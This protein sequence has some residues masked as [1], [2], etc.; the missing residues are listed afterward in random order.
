VGLTVGILGVLEVCRDGAAVPVAG[1]RAQLLLHLLAAAEGRTVSASAL[2]EEIWGGE[3]A[4]D[5]ANA[6][7]SLVSR[8]R[9]MLGDAGAV[10]Q[11][12][13]GYRLVADLDSHRFAELGDDDP[14]AA[15]RLW[16]GLPHL[17]LD[18]RLLDQDRQRLQRLHDSARLRLA[19]RRLEAGEA[20]A[21]L[22][23]LAGLVAERPLD[24]RARELHIRALHA[25]GRQAEALAAYEE[26]RVL[27]RDE[28]GVDPSPTLQRL[29]RD[30]LR[31]DPSLV[32]EPARLP[33]PVSTFIGREEDLARIRRLLGDN[34]LVTLVGPGGAGKTRLALEAARDAGDARL[35]ELAPLRSGGDIPG[36]VADALG[37]REVN[38]SDRQ[39]VPTDAL[40]RACEHL[41]GRSAL[42]VLDNCEHLVEDAARVAHE[43]LSG[44]P[45]L[46][47]LATSREP[48]GVTG[49][50][51]LSV[52]ALPHADGLRLF[53]ERALAARHDLALDEEVAGR[54]VDR[55]D[56]MPLAIEL[57]A[58]R[59]RTLSP[60]EIDRRL[61]DRFR[62]LTV[63]SRTAAPR[64]QTLRAVIDWSWA[65]LDEDERRV[66]RRL[67]V[68]AGDATLD[69]A[70]AVCGEGT[71]P[72]LSSLVD[73]SLVVLRDA[74][75]IAYR[76][77][78]TVRA[79]ARDRLR[80]AGDESEARNLHAA[81]L[82]ALVERCDGRLRG[83]GQIDAMRELDAAMPDVQTAVDW[84]V[85]SGAGDLSHRLV[86]GLTYYFMVR[87]GRGTEGLIDRVSAMPPPDD[88][89]LRATLLDFAVV[90]AG[91][92]RGMEWSAEHNAEA[93]RLY[94]RTDRP[95]LPY[96]GVMAP[97][98]AGA[99]NDLEAAVHAA[100]E[101]AADPRIGPWDRAMTH[102]VIGYLTSSSPAPEESEEAFIRA[103]AEFQA[104][105][106]RLGTAGALSGL[107]R[108]A[109]RRDHPDEAI[110]LLEEA[111][112]HAQ[113]LGAHEDEVEMRLRHGS[114]VA[115]YR[116]R[117]RGLREL[118]EAAREAEALGSRELRGH[119]TLLRAEVARLDGDPGP[120]RLLYERAI[121][122]VAGTNYIPPL[123]L[124]ARLRLAQMA[125]AAR[126]LDEARRRLTEAIDQLRGSARLEIWRPHL[127]VAIWFAAAGVALA[128]GEAP[129]AARLL[130]L[131]EESGS[132]MEPSDARDLEDLATRVRAALGDE[133]YEAARAEGMTEREALSRI[134]Q[135][136][137]R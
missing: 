62:L 70:E 128:L 27:L 99:R 52:G 4:R 101:A 91:E 85:G 15:L 47:V 54:I 129:L 113:A 122:I 130:G 134:D 34:R 31:R 41:R 119:A 69:L 63:G 26:T 2:I 81:A 43:L 55:L 121:E 116:D 57:A 95:R 5:L 3:D 56:G 83:P 36:A 42:L 77:L 8:V 19:E 137:R 105:G 44:A 125:A 30:M 75:R 84:Y 78:D 12:G 16:R 98:V 107:S 118:D 73:R 132:L 58:A 112:P 18:S 92:E 67:G 106:D 45:G 104:L 109:E 103:A 86:L 33:A 46:C 93:E 135:L 115:R 108:A 126:S 72:V 117:E 1:R 40:T 32:A 79:Y 14:E 7:Q 76:L 53:R 35:V 74:G 49:E 88:P 123:D 23:D 28:L 96:L 29:H 68:F 39:S 124:F 59:A 82:L 102:V 133:V 64:H 120:A 111:L 38:I 9:G 90:A 71:E 60:A 51:S 114:L 20:E 131:V 100:R 10:L 11:Q 97:M 21:A 110:R 94:D 13:A 136:L 89:W 24:E 50:V 80:E 25:A 48:L 17:G 87:G 66:L 127:M 37:L 61:D 22:T 65:L 6:L